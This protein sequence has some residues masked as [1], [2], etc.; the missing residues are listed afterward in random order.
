MTEQDEFFSFDEALDRLRLKEEELKRLVSEGEI[1]AFRDGETMKL[2]RTD[3]D[4]LRRELMGGDVVDLDDATDDVVLADP[5]MVTEELSA[6]DTLLEDET[7]LTEE[8]DVADLDDLDDLDEIEELDELEEVEDD[9]PKKRRRP[10]PEPEPMHP[11]AL[12]GIFL[13][14]LLLILSF[15]VLKNSN[16][17]ISD[18]ADSIAQT[19]GGA[20]AEEA[21][22]TPAD[23]EATDE[24]AS[25]DDAADPF[26]DADDATDGDSTDGDD[27]DD[28]SSEG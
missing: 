5:G 9:E 18:I 21:D 6:A 4:N 12:A 27:S 11:M 1:R 23:G 16:G 28:D 3:V 13:T 8:L 19:F 2:R 22:A 25:E 7:L 15:P 26:G 17:G 10:E 24:D 20:P 14:S